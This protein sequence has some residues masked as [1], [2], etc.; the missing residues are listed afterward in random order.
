MSAQVPFKS[1]EETIEEISKSATA[2]EFV[3][4]VV[5][6]YK[7][8]GKVVVPVVASYKIEV[9]Q[10]TKEHLLDFLRRIH[11]FTPILRIQFGKI[12]SI[13]P[14]PEVQEFMKLLK[15]P[16]KSC[17]EETPCEDCGK[18]DK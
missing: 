16:C 18:E 14:P 17:G 3:L 4:T 9:Y 10:S 8:Q 6:D 5:S 12:I 13:T 15:Q 11:E 7:T 2:N 1:F